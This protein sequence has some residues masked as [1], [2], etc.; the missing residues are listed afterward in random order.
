MILKHTHCLIRLDKKRWKCSD[1]KCFFTASS[2]KVRG[3]ASRC[4]QC[5]TKEIILTRELMR[6]AHPRC[7]D[8][9][10]TAEARRHRELKNLLEQFESTTTLPLGES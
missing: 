4:T 8:C 6:R 5:R 7:L 10:D 9:A 3:K 1:A 2:E